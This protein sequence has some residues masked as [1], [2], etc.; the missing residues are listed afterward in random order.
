VLEIVQIFVPTGLRLEFA[1]PLP[2]YS[3]NVIDEPSVFDYGPQHQ[4]TCGLSFDEAVNGGPAFGPAWWDG[5]ALVCGYSRGKIW[6]TKLV[7]SGGLRGRKPAR[8][9]TPVLTVD[10]CVSPGGD[11]VVSTHG[12]E[13]DWGSG[14][15]GLGRLF[16]I[17]YADKELA[18]PVA[19]WSAGPAEFDLELVSVLPRSVR[20]EPVVHRNAANTRVDLP[21]VLGGAL[22]GW[23]LPHAKGLT[24]G[25]EMAGH[26]VSRSRG[27]T[28]R[29]PRQGRKSPY[30]R[31]RPG[32]TDVRATWKTAWRH[33]PSNR[34]HGMTKKSQL[35]VTKAT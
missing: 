3:P 28:D 25:P 8:H 19:P 5:D 6:R 2:K 13:P 17:R 7:D 4:S 15:N 33:H 1:Q 20:V 18:Q 14:P 21:A 30:Q 27:A 35:T 9:L 12:G 32:A 22:V 31:E 26:Q 29:R 34:G 24:V 23:A 10:A 16:K 11:L